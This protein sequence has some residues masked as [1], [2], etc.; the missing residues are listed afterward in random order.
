MGL[1]QPDVI[2]HWGVGIKTL[3]E[4]VSPS[5]LDIVLPEGSSQFN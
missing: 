4:W 3:K 5:V 1:E 2:L